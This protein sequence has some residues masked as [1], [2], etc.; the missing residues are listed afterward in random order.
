[1]LPPVFNCNNKTCQRKTNTRI[2]EQLLGG[3][4]CAEGTQKEDQHVQK[5]VTFLAITFAYH[6]PSVALY[7]THFQ[8]FKRKEKQAVCLEER[9]YLHEGWGDDTINKVLDLQV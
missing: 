5:K 1:M 2:K 6:C 4:V 9:K 7:A 3:S 8:Y